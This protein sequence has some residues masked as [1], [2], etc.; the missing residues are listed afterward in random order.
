[1]WSALATA[2][3]DG[4]EK[5]KGFLAGG[6]DPAVGGLRF[7]R[8]QRQRGAMERSNLGPGELELRGNYETHP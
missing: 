3:E 8:G 1:V 5:E 6:A 2:K 4:R 7:I